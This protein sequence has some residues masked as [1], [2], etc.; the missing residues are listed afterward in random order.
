V[1]PGATT[2]YWLDRDGQR[3]GPYAEADILEGVETGAVRATDLLRVEGMGEGIPVWEVLAQLGAAPSSPRAR[4]SAR[5]PP[6]H[7]APAA[8]VADRD[9]TGLETV[10]YAGF[11][12]RLAA[13]VVDVS[14]MFAAAL[15]LGII[16]GAIAFFLGLRLP[17]TRSALGETLLTGVA[18]AVIWLYFAFLES[19]PH[20]ATI[21]KQV[22]YLQVLTARGHHRISFLRAAWRWAARWLSW[23]VFLLG[24]LM[25]PFTPRKRALH[26]LLSGTVVVALAP[27]SRSRIGLVLAVALGL[28]LA[29]WIALSLW[30]VAL[31]R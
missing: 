1:E 19:S 20:G 11:W 15:V 12:V 29:G 10:R 17:D 31:P 24:Y 28:P 14:V 6:P 16:A 9:T 30:P 26:D 8:R 13:V 2:Q 27:A 18:V 7:R 4:A 3:L 23:A 22:F 25:Q 5:A 21:G